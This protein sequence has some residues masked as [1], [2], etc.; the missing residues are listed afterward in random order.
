MKIESR[1]SFLLAA[2]V[3]L[4][5]GLLPRQAPPLTVFAAASL[6]DAFKDI[7]GTFTRL[8][9]G[10]TIRFNLAGSQQLVAQLEQGAQADVFASA[11]ESSMVYARDHSLISGEPLVFAHNRL[12]VIVP[13]ANPMRIR[14]LT[15]LARRGVKLVLAGETVPAGRYSRDVLHNLSGA[16]GFSPDYAS[17]TLANVVSNEETVKGVVA[18]VQLG[19][20]DAGIVYRTDVTADLARIVTVMEIPGPQNVL[21]TYP[22]AVVRGSALPEVASA[23]ITFLLSADGQRILGRHGFLPAGSSP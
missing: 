1:R 12:V 4:L 22:V 11:D 7:S 10:T 19:E 6:T 20:A 18:K 13:R 8:H 14:T 16:T 3:F 2:A 21:A 15:D 9:P 23:F 5:V 17:R